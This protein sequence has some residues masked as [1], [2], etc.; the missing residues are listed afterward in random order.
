MENKEGHSSRRKMPIYMEGEEEKPKQKRSIQDYFEYSKKPQTN[1][2]I[3]YPNVEVNNN[4]NYKNLNKYTVTLDNS[5]Q[6]HFFQPQRQA[7]GWVKRNERFAEKQRSKR[8]VDIISNKRQVATHS[9][10]LN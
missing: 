7:E 6:L 10:A 4:N 3:I 2:T 8:R 1:R 5:R 9:I